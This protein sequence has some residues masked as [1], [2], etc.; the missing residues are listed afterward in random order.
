VSKV[1]ATNDKGCDNHVSWVAPHI[2]VGDW[3]WGRYL[4][5]SR[6]FIMY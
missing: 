1:T 2:Q 5:F 6:F 4:P 3:L